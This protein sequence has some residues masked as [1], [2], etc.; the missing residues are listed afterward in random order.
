MVLLA[1]LDSDNNR[2]ITVNVLFYMMI[3]CFYENMKK[4]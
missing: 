1:W 2:N 4:A 3:E